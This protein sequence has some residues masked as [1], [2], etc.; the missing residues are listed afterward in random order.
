MNPPNDKIHIVLL[1]DSIFDNATYVPDG[2]PVI[3][4]VR[5][6]L[7]KGWQTTLL[8]IDGAVAADVETQ[9]AGVP[10]TATH[11]IVSVGGNDALQSIG[12]LGTQVKSV[13]EALFIL[14]EE[15]VNFQQRY[16]R[17]LEHIRHLNLPVAACSI[18]NAIPSLGATEKTALALF[19]ETILSEVFRAGLPLID[20]RHV[21]NEPDDYSPLSDIEPSH[22]GGEK[23]A[24]AI[25][26]LLKIHNFSQR[27]STVISGTSLE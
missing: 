16:H 18:Y 25:L 10:T 9:V 27:H 12:L 3:E 15:C 11:L 26:T 5:R 8:A 4:H 13:G 22:Q 19:N 24:R 6:Q 21:C 23:I 7:P 14:S 2:T 17:M 20:L 1:G